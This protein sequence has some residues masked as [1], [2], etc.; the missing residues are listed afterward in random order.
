MK[1]IELLSPESNRRLYRVYGP[2]QKPFSI[3]NVFLKFLENKDSAPNTVRSYAYDLIGYFKFLNIVSIKWDEI[4]ID[5]WVNYVQHLKHSTSSDSISVLPVNSAQSRASSTINRALAAISSFYKYNHEK[6]DIALPNIEELLRNPYTNSHKPLLSYAQRSRPKSVKRATRVIGKQAQSQSRPIELSLDLLVALVSGCNN[7]R[8]KLILML[9]I[10]TGMRIG[11]VLG[12]RHEDI[13]SYDSKIRIIY[14]LDNA[15]G[16]YS[17]SRTEYQ[18][19]ISNEW[20]NLYTDFLVTDYDDTDSDYIFTT[21]YSRN[22]PKDNPLSYP[23]VQALLTRLSKKIGSKATCHQFR[24]THATDLIRAG[25]PIEMVSKR[26]GHKSIETTKSTYE[27]L[28]SEDIKNALQKH[29]PRNDFL[30]SL[31]SYDKVNS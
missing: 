14:R 1:V 12:L 28:S 29:T 17:K 31:Y 25:V 4:S 13:V 23:T 10:E 27:H 7:K 19:S 15:N 21:L 5:D 11:Q 20:L 3:I 26:L 22:G 2:N 18:V 30:K 24:H 16:V 6:N 8:D 9:L